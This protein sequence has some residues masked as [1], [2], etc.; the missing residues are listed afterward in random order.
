MTVIWCDIFRYN[1]TVKIILCFDCSR[2][3]TLESSLPGPMPYLERWLQ[4]FCSSLH[5]Y[6]LLVGQYFFSS[7]FCCH[8][9]SDSILLSHTPPWLVPLDKPGVGVFSPSDYRMGAT[10]EQAVKQDHGCSRLPRECLLQRGWWGW[11]Q[12]LLRVH[13]RL[14]RSSS[15]SETAE[16]T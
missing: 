14:V 5:L 13:Q 10:L 9:F 4:T 6:C 7:E 15:R 8:I 2:Q 16:G 11:H 3:L 1:V 12:R